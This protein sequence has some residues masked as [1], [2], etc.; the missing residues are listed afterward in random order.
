MWQTEQL[1]AARE[2]T[3]PADCGPITEQIQNLADE[4]SASYARASGREDNPSP[5]RW[6]TLELTTFV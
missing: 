2:R 1:T 6:A 5:E 4:I 3:L